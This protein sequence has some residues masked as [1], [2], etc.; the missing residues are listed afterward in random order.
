MSFSTGRIYGIDDD[1]TMITD[2]GKVIRIYSDDL[3]ESRHQRFI[4]LLRT[5]QT[6]LILHNIDIVRRI[7]IREGDRVE[8]RGEYEFNEKGGLVH[9]T[10]HDPQNIHEPGW[11]KHAG[12]VYQ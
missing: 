8:F 6:L 11:I 4:V 9:W 7:P 3:H 12:F 2:H 10:H 1:S 5:E